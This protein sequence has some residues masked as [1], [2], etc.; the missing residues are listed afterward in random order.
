MANGALWIWRVW[1]QSLGRY[2]K[3]GAAIRAALAAAFM[4]GFR[5]RPARTIFATNNPFRARRLMCAAITGTS[6][7]VAACIARAIATRGPPVAH[8]MKLNSRNVQWLGGRGFQRERPHR[9]A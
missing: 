6:L 5:A 1:N 7:S 8:R 2:P 3:H 9:Q 4:F